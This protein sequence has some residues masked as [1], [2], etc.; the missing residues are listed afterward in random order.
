M[1]FLLWKGLIEHLIKQDA[2][3]LV[4][5]THYCSTLSWM[6]YE[7]YEDWIHNSTKTLKLTFAERHWLFC[8]CFCSCWG[9]KF[10]VKYDLARLTNNNYSKNTNSTY[11]ILVLNLKFCWPWDFLLFLRTLCHLRLRMATFRKCW[12]HLFTRKTNNQLMARP[13]DV[14]DK[15]PKNDS[16]PSITLS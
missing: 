9:I 6:R 11:S 7:G 1:E 5:H 3:E 8:Q 10:F 4:T 15:N 2:L 16:A 13:K 14:L 12:S